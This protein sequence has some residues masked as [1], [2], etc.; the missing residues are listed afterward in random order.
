MAN[1]ETDAEILDWI[2]KHSED[3]FRQYVEHHTFGDR[4]LEY[5]RAYL[6]RIDGQRAEI[7]EDRVL[8]ATQQAAGA[9]LDQAETARQALR[10]SKWAFGIAIVSAFVAVAG[11]LSG[12]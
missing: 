12:K 6:E 11:L 5:A 4:R 9:A 7:R 3:E 10:I 8:L 2:A 1:F